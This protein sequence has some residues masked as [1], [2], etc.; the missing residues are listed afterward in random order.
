[1]NITFEN[2]TVVITG[3]AGGLGKAMAERFAADGARVALCDLRGAEDAA[4]EIGGAARG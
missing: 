2:K 1:M 3:A 4:A